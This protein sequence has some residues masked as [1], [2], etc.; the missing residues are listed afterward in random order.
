MKSSATSPLQPKLDNWRCPRVRGLERL[1]ESLNLEIHADADLAH[2]LEPQ[3]VV[4]TIHG[5]HER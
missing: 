5:A 3:V 1:G 4:L 2:A